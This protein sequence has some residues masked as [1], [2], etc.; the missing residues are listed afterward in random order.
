MAQIFIREWDRK[1]PEHE[2]ILG[3]TVKE[4]TII[5]DALQEYCEKHKRKKN[6]SILHLQLEKHLPYNNS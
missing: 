5:I 2:A 4:S 1:R 3:L 6:A